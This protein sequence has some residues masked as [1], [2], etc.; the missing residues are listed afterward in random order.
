SGLWSRLCCHHDLDHHDPEAFPGRKG[1]LGRIHGGRSQCQ[2]R[3]GGIGS[4]LI[5][6]VGRH[7]SAEFFCCLQVRYLWA[8][9]VCLWSLCSGSV[10]F[11]PGHR[12]QAQVQERPH[13]PRD[14]IDSLRPKGTL[15]LPVLRPPHQHHCQCHAA[16]GRI[17]C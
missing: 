6:D 14:S 5:M 8:F 13:F 7:S 16:L 11:H 4:G 15:H 10:V 12:A 1:H 17:G 2:D 9:L 3:P